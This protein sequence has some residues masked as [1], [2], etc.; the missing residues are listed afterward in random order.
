MNRQIINIG[1]G[2]FSSC[3][4]NNFQMNG[5]NCEFTESHGVSEELCI[6]WKRMA[7]KFADCIQ[8]LGGI[9]PDNKMHGYWNVLIDMKYLNIHFFDKNKI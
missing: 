5:Y 8:S 1:V 6:Y 2:V 3:A 9:N 4:G 7:L